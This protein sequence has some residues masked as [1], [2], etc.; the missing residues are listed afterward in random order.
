[1]ASAAITGRQNVDQPAEAQQAFAAIA[2]NGRDTLARMREAVGSLRS[3]APL[4]PQPD[5]SQL[6]SL[7]AGVGGRLEVVGEPRPLPSGVELSGYRIVEQLLRTTTS[8][9]VWIR[10][11]A[12]E[13]ELRVTIPV[14]T[15]AQPSELVAPALAERA[16]IHG[17]SL[18][19]TRLTGQLQWVARLPLTTSP[20]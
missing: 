14:S 7:V 16:A 18:I 6:A 3:D 20:A 2:R 5:L 15:M 13:L 19:A 1:M 11:G 4:H 8:P 12:H 17:G 10:F 9:Q